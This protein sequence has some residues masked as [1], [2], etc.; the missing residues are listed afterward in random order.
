LI[1][2]TINGIVLSVDSME[3]RWIVISKEELY[4]NPVES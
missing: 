4:D 3:V 2:N 1:V